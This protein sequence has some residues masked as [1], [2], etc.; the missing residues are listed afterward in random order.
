MKVTYEDARAAAVA[1]LAPDWPPD[2]GTLYADK[3]GLEDSLAFLVPIGARE[4]LVDG[5]Q[6]FVVLG[7]DVVTVD[8]ITGA[9]VTLD[10]LTDAARIDAMTPTR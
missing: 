6:S 5:D 8:K 7:V 3:I 9:I 1:Y 2:G 10:I 4:F